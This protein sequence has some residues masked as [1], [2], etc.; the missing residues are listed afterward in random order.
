M[1]KKRR[2]KPSYQQM[3]KFKQ[4][5]EGGK[6]RAQVARENGYFGSYLSKIFREYGIVLNVKTQKEKVM[7]MT[8]E[9]LTAEEIAQKLGVRVQ[10]VYCTMRNNGIFNPKEHTSESRLTPQEQYEIR[11]K[12]RMEIRRIKHKIGIRD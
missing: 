12:H 9:G 10:S 2:E 11:E 3:L 5:I 6:T 1:S 8:L 7:E 4:M